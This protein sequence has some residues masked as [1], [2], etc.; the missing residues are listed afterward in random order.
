MERKSKTLD[1]NTCNTEKDSLNEGFAKQ[2]TTTLN[3]LDLFSGWGGWVEPW[4][5]SNVYRVHID[6]VDIIKRH[7]NTNHI[8]DARVFKADKKYHLVYA[9]P[10]CNYYFSQIKRTNKIKST[11]EDKKMSEELAELSFKYAKSALLGYVIE[12]PYTG[13]MPK[14]YSGYKIVDYS[15]YNYPM[16]KRTAIWTNLPLKLKL[17]ERK[18]Y[19]ST[20]IGCLSL[21]KRNKIPHLLSRYVKWIFCNVFYNKIQEFKK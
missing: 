3:I 20:Q 21:E 4:Y 9:S 5:N 6:S 13:L 15:M 19:N 18:K 10:P 11:S 1:K 17:Q 16:R 7:V 2:V 8:L 12:N 14:L